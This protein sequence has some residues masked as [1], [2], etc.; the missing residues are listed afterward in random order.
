MN[1]TS[2]KKTLQINA[3]AHNVWKVL[4]TPTFMTAWTAALL[5][6]TPVE[7]EPREGGTFKFLDGEG[8]GLRAKVVE[9]VPE[10]V[11]KY[12]Y[13]A[14][15]V[16]NVEQTDSAEF[17]KW[18]ECFDVYELSE[19]NGVTTLNME[20]VNPSEY[21]AV[22]QGMW[23]DNMNR[24]KEY[25]EYLQQLEAEGYT[26]LTVAEMP[27][28]ENPEEHTH[29]IETVHI[30]LSGELTTVEKGET[31]LTKTGEKI[32]FPA[33]TT[34]TATADAVDRLMMLGFKS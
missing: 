21:D 33:G 17:K 23:D 1:T 26:D 22:F 5:N 10:K 6:G 29:D 16:E 24:V 11:F 32:V 4:T 2:I 12:V 31:T 20:T 18:S 3:S 25:S 8:S 34:H 27:Y 13:T 9:F 15:I 14:D 28:S 30:I 7:G 19:N